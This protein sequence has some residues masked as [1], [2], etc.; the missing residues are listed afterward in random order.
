MTLKN[1]DKGVLDPKD[2]SLM[3]RIRQFT[4]AGQDLVLSNHSLFVQKAR[5]MPGCSFVIGFDTYVRILNP[6]YYQDSREVMEAAIAEIGQI[7]CSFVV[8]GR[9][10]DGVFTAADQGLVPPSLS[11]MFVFLAESEFRRDVSSTQLR[12]DGR[13]L[14][15]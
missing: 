9:S 5:L 1:A 7:G 4:S 12:E 8:G 11:Q 13:G 15:L 2:P 14:Q 3:A 6:K 10:I